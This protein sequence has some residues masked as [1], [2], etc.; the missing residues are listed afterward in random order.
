MVPNSVALEIVFSGFL[1]FAAG[2]EA[3][4]I[5]KKAYNVAAATTGNIEKLLSP[6][7]LKDGKLLMSKRNKPTPTQI[8]EAIILVS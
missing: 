8:L 3:D 7:K 5:P 1:I 2:I 4:S 6:V